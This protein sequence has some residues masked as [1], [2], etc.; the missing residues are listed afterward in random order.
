MSDGRVKINPLSDWSAAD[1]DTYFAK[2]RLPQHPLEE[3]GFRSIGC[4]T[5]TARTIAGE[6]SRAG[7]W[8][9]RDKTEC[10]IHLPINTFKD[11]GADI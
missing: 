2:Y 3:D 1:V 4:L 8:R 9:G 11:F 6:D 7:R 10:G 5:C